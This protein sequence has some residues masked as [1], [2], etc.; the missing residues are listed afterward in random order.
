MKK[1]ILTV[2]VGL[3][4]LS[5]Q[6]EDRVFS[7]NQELSPSVEW[8]KSD[9]KTFTVPVE[10]IEDQYNLSLAFRFTEG[11]PYKILKVKVTEISPSKKESSKEYDLKI[12]N[13]K[14]EYI[15]E[16]G[17]DIWDSEHLIEEN[18]KYTEK[19]KYTYKIE[20]VMPTDVVNMAMEIGVVL[21]KVK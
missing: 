17:L 18:L 6:S 15:G 19:G 20:H 2:F 8:L 21:D 5:C 7:D 14:G 3:S 1:I 9:V 12:V 4:L 13:E 11:F 10:N 16:P